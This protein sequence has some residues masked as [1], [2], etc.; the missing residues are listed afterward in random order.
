M[1]QGG[2]GLLSRVRAGDRTEMRFSS[3]TSH[4]HVTVL[5][6]LIRPF[7]LGTQLE[8]SHSACRSYMLSLARF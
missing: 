2:V 3:F 8:H 7:L 1:E 5:C 6:R 4:T